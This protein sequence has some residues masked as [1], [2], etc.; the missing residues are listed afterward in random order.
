MTKNYKPKMVVKKSCAKTCLYEKAGC[1]M[2]L[3]L[4]PEVN[5]INKLKQALKYANVLA[6]NFYLTNNAT[7]RV[8]SSRCYA[9]LLTLYDLRR[10][11][12]RSA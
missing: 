6:L 1:K 11:P 4:T 9:E 5:F 8:L 2:L 3:I 12:V 10:V 7:L